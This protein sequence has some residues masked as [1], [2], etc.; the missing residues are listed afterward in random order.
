MQSDES[1]APDPVDRAI[2]SLTS[3]TLLLFVASFVYIAETFLWRVLLV[4]TLPPTDWSYFSLG[5]AYAGL[6]TALGGFGLGKAIARNLPH[7]QSDQERRGLVRV[8]LVYGSA[9]SVGTTGVM[10]V[11]SGPISSAM[12]AAPMAEVLALLA[13]ATA[14]S[15][16]TG[17]LVSVFQ[18]FEDVRPNAYFVQMLPP[19]LFVVFLALL[20]PLPS[21]KPSL[22]STLWAFALA[23]MAA[24]FVTVLYALR[25]LPAALPRGPRAPGLARPTFAFALPLFI[26]TITEFFSGGGDT[27]IL[28]A[29]HPL[30]VGAYA[31]SLSMGRLMLIGIAAL[32]FI[33]LPVASQLDRDHDVESI[34]Q[35]YV[36]MTK[37]TLLT[38]LPLLLVFTVFPGPSLGFVY[39]ETYAHTTVPLQILAVGAFASVL[40]GPSTYAQIALGQ[41]RLLALNATA[42]AVADLAVAAVLVPTYGSVGAAVA[43]ATA[44]ALYP[45][46]SL[47]EIGLSHNIHPFRRHFLFP[48]AATAVPLVGVFLV[49][50]PIAPP[51]ALPILALLVVPWFFGAVL[52]TRSVD[53]GDIRLVRLLECL[54]GIKFGR[55]RRLFDRVAGAHLDRRS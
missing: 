34:R 31:A 22:T 42:S 16:L 29:Y 43:W 6:F 49:I 46:L 38:S 25:R 28:G 1:S 17:R 8:I 23:N 11:L 50:L 10:Y 4:R 32:S 39:G 54:L 51:W 44:T 3:G 37:W 48:I 35:L 24:F 12:G 14:F 55:L 33:F 15:V 2:K 21:F 41:P 52:L 27:L 26:V 30:S 18:G 19:L 5:L 36:T 20:G 53:T 7:A 40:V 45:A 47:V 9:L 13:F